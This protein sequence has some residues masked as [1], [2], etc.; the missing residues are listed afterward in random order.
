MSEA[1]F[2][3]IVVQ[4]MAQPFRKRLPRTVISETTD[5]DEEE[6]HQRPQRDRK[7]PKY[8]LDNYEVSQRF[9]FRIIYNSAY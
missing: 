2:R 8:L 1:Q 5:S 9:Y 7:A 6:R 4:S 3:Y